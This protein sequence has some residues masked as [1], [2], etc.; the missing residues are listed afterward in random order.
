MSDS[1][2]GKSQTEED[3][4]V[5]QPATFL[6][7]SMRNDGYKGDPNRPL[8]PWKSAKYTETVNQEF[9]ALYRQLDG[10]GNGEVDAVRVLITTTIQ[11]EV[12]KVRESEELENLLAAFAFY[13]RCRIENLFIFPETKRLANEFILAYSRL[14]HSGRSYEEVKK[15][16]K[17]LRCVWPM[18][19]F[20]SDIP[21]LFGAKVDL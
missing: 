14:I 16:A 10:E 18:P 13:M 7:S 21:E 2:L 1:E 8:G 12:G 6:E 19:V 3:S 9:G 20:D 4:K 5:Y 15:V 17:N 11:D